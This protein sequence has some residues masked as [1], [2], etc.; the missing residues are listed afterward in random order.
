L[1][2]RQEVHDDQCEA[3]WYSL[4][5]VA[6]DLVMI[7][8]PHVH[9]LLRANIWW[10][11]GERDVVIDAGLG[12]VSLRS[13]IPEMFDRNPL[14]IISHAHLDHAGGAY[15]FEEV[16]VHETE[17]A[18]LQHPPLTSLE[19]S[20]LYPS[21]GIPLDDVNRHDVM[22]ERLPHPAYRLDEYRLNPVR[23]PRRLKDGAV[24]R[25]A[26]SEFE[27]ISTPGH[28]PGSICVMDR[29]KKRLYTGDV[30]YE[31]RILDELRGS[32]RTDYIDTM[33]LLQE[34]DV[35]QAL[36]GHGDVLNRTQIRDIASNYIR[37]HQVEQNFSGRII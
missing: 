7:T 10:I 2:W 6:P 24:I 27:V 12:V 17:A 20:E 29:A 16:W 22:L 13:S 1:S 30:I 32:D 28:S 15:E 23:A 11:R 19:T 26:E 36:P 31:G 4:T 9:P 34:L 21:L 5:T 14:L 35:D 25:T 8:E 37:E 18:T 33:R 3:S